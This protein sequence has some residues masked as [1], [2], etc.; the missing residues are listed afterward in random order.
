MKDFDFC[1]I[2]IFSKNVWVIS[3]K[4]KK[5]ITTTNASEKN[6]MNLGTKQTKHQWTKV[7]NFTTDQ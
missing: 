1:I 5:G 4:D 6:L 3:L 7:V 2:N